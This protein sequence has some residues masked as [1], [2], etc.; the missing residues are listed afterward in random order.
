[1][2][3]VLFQ[4]ASSRSTRVAFRSH[5][6]SPRTPASLPALGVRAA[7]L[8]RSKPLRVVGGARASGSHHWRAPTLRGTA[9]ALTLGS[10]SHAKLPGPPDRKTVPGPPATA[11]GYQASPPIPNGHPTVRTF[12]PTP[13]TSSRL[14]SSYP[15]L[16]PLRSRS[17]W[18]FGLLQLHA[19]DPLAVNLLAGENPENWQSLATVSLL[20]QLLCSCA[21]ACCLHTRQQR[22]WTPATAGSLGRRPT[23]AQPERANRAL[24]LHSHP[25]SFNDNPSTSL[26]QLFLQFPK[27]F[28]AHFDI[29]ST[30]TSL[31]HHYG[32]SGG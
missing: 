30:S 17:S 23:P 8:C 15:S 22:E 18:T 31:R 7:A 2:T 12:R 3:T 21:G 24:P 11:G 1:M 25:C 4:Q 29:S 10:R 19:A 20:A 32:R 14:A 9:G 13:S 28:W 27:V 26:R 5:W 6:L 16:R